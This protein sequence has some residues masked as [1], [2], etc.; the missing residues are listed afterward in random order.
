MKLFCCVLVGVAVSLGCSLHAASR[1]EAERKQ[2]KTVRFD[3]YAFEHDGLRVRTKALAPADGNT[4]TPALLKEEVRALCVEEDRLFE[5]AIDECRPASEVIEDSLDV[6][7]TLA[8]QTRVYCGIS[9][10]NGIDCRALISLEHRES[11]DNAYRSRDEE[12]A[13]RWRSFSAILQ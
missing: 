3:T 7:G 1:E 13:R 6:I 10:P 12:I 8:A 5:V 11:L 9:D 4:G 2:K